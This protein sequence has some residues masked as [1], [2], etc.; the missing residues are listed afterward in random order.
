MVSEAQKHMIA[1]KSGIEHT[2]R[3]LSEAAVNASAA[4]AAA[5]LNLQMILVE[6]RERASKDRQDLIAQIATLINSTADEQDK[7]L[8]ERIE[9]VQEEIGATQTQLKVA[10][11]VHKEGMES[12]SA[13]EENFYSR[14]CDA[15]ETVRCVLARDWQVSR[16]CSVD[17]LERLLTPSNRTLKT[18]TPLFKI[19]RSLFM[20]RPS[21][22]LKNKRKMS[23]SRCKPLMNS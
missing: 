22:S 9:A 15:K 5:Q 23:E 1:Q 8:T 11:K 3:E 14:L 12:W 13:R 17:L 2:G 4:T 19:L 18:E 16:I 21:S 20:L 6:E 7:R 10:S